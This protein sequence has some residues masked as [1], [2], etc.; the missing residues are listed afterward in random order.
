MAT[1]ALNRT[2]E[3]LRR[4]WM[5]QGLLDAS[6]GSYWTAYTGGTQDSIIHLVKN[7][8][9]NNEGT[10]VVFQHNAQLSAPPVEGRQTAFGTGEE[11]KQYANTLEVK[12]YRFTAD[13]GDRFNGTT[14]G[15]ASLNEHSNSRDLLAQK[16][17]KWKDQNIFDAMQGSTEQPAS[18]TIAL[19]NGLTYN[20]LI[21]LDR[22]IQTSTGFTTG[23]RRAP[24]KPYMGEMKSMRG[25]WLLVVDSF[26]AAQLKM[27]SNYQTIASTSDV[28][29][30]DNRA[31]TMVLGKIGSLMIMEAPTFFGR[32][33]G[34]VSKLNNSHVERAGMRLRDSTGK[35]MGHNGYV[36]TGAQTSRAVLLGAGAVQMAMGQEPD[37]MVQPSPD[38]GIVT[39]SACEVW[40]NVQKTVLEAELAD[41]EEAKLADFDFGVV[42]VDITI[43]A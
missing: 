7:P 41:N 26:A 14:Y 43:P 20:E 27:D 11:K 35:W 40:T 29:G 42:A 32:T 12:R 1:T 37:Y 15:S 16:Y 38:Y 17:Q 25:C 21:N 19:P 6:M 28:R 5:R 18:H 9:A 36:A 23:D 34:T 33:S 4:K 2:S 3:L 31:L 13:N 30:N 22:I 10:R 8:A 39:E 24:L